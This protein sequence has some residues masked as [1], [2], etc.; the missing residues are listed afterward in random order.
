MNSSISVSA[1]GRICLFGE[2]QDY[3]GLP[4]IACAISLR[5]RV[6]GSR[7][8]DDLV[9]IDL[10]DLG[11]REGFRIGDGEIP[12]E[13]DRDYF[14]SS[15]NVLLR[16]GFTFSCG[17]YCRLTGNIPINAGT[18]S[19]SALVVAWIDLLARMSDQAAALERPRL[20][21]LAYAAEVVEFS[22]SG[23]MMDQYTISVGG[24]VSLRSQPEMSVRKVEG[25]FGTFVLGN[26]GE[27]KDTQGILSRIRGGVEE[28]VVTIRAAYPDFCLHDVRMDEL[29]E[30]NRLLDGRQRQL[31]QGTV[32]NRDLTRE[33]LDL[34][35][36]RPLDHERL[37]RMLTEH[38]AILR[39]VLDISTPK[40]DSML[41][42]ALG[43]GAMGGK[44]NGS[45]G[46]GCM[47]AYAPKDPENVLEAVAGFGD[48]WI[49]IVDD[50]AR[51]DE[52]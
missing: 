44:I 33:A 2:H 49:V 32:R 35:V 31:L 46:G 23:G 24:A 51:M 6:S 47:F 29:S 30:Y 14:R 27:A 25:G 34:L 21:S 4:V 9:I 45:G 15:Y 11:G 20:A 22:E 48:A 43:A 41:E 40:I 13:S 17:L 7:R 52:A 39:D 18:S 8:D 10:P 3:L 19:S 36:S 37:G 1:P 16:E 50:G 28:I 5:M 42:A 26:S 12:Y 38:H